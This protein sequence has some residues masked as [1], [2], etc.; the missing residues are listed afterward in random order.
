M[1]ETL[2]TKVVCTIEFH[3]KKLRYLPMNYGKEENLA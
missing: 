3:Q 1:G 2:L